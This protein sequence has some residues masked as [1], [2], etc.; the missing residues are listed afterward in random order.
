MNYEIRNAN[1]ERLLA[2]MSPRARGK[3]KEQLAL[4]WIY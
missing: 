3:H 4:K 1:R 2:G